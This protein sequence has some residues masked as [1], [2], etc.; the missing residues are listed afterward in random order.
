M[1]NNIT[2]DTELTEYREIQAELRA[3]GKAELKP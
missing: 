1:V 3:K 2:S